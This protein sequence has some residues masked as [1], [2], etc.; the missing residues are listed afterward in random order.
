V[1]T[2]DVFRHPDAWRASVR[3]TW[4][5]PT[6]ASRHALRAAAR[7]TAFTEFLSPHRVQVAVPATPPCASRNGRHNLPV[8]AYD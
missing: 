8:N 1:A 7:H 2:P 5:R 6:R 4:H 3:S